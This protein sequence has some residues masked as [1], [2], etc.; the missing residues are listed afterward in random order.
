MI[1]LYGNLTLTL[2]QIPENIPWLNVIISILIIQF[3]LYILF[4]ENMIRATNKSINKTLNYIP[5]ETNTNLTPGF[6]YLLDI[7]TFFDN[8]TRKMLSYQQ[9][10]N[11]RVPSKNLK[12]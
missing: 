11:K 2:P 8:M 6:Q 12:I 4:R 7:K 3:I 5:I 10:K 1:P 9:S